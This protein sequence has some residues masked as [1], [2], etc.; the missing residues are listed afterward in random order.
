MTDHNETEPTE[1][2]GHEGSPPMS[3]DH[4]IPNPDVA[5]DTVVTLPI[6]A[7]RAW[8]GR[9]GVTRM[10]EVGKGYAGLL[11]PQRFD[12]ILNEDLRSLPVGADEPR[13][14]AVGDVITDGK[15]DVRVVEIDEDTSTILFES[16]YAP[17]AGQNK[18]MHYTW[19]IRVGAGEA[20]GT[21]VMTSRTR[22][23]GLKYPR[24]GRL[25][26]PKVDTFA[27]RI[28]AEGIARDDADTSKPPLRRIIGIKALAAAGKVRDLK[29]KR[30]R[31]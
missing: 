10:G 14:L 5:Y 3:G 9:F 21:T 22:M 12:P 15:G 16:V 31:K 24:I 25:L 30:S 28:L 27:S 17:G 11:L 23:E 4:I 6:D 20:E 13:R 1:P 2:I 8:S 29:R 18:P 26:W 19:Q 7:E